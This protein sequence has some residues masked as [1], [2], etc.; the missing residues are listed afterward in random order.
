ML[1]NALQTKIEKKF[2]GVISYLCP[3]KGLVL[4]FFSRSYH[5]LLTKSHVI[6]HH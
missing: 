5:L 3:Q 1:Q 6:G 4:G 2:T